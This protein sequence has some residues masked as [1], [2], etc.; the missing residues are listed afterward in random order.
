MVVFSLVHAMNGLFGPSWKQTAVQLLLTF[1]AGAAFYVTRMTT[2]S[3]V[4]RSSGPGSGQRTL[5]W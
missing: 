3:L 4:A 1:V 2:G 5:R